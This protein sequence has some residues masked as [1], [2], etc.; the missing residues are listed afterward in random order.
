MYNYKQKK[1][2]ITRPCDIAGCTNDGEH[3]APKNRHSSNEYY[4]FCLPHV[5]DYNKKW[6]YFQ[7]MSAEEIDNFRDDAVTGHRPTWNHQIPPQMRDKMIRDG[8]EK[9]LGDGAVKTKPRL[10][11]LV[12]KALAKMELEHP[13]VKKQIKKQ[14]KTL[15]K[16]YHPDVNNN[17]KIAEERFKEITESYKYLWENYCAD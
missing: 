3:R 11:P 16:L 8:L 1:E 12:K 4:W 15:V 13:V 6:N 10:P 5:Q 7:G 9:L 14:Y 2:T 17:D